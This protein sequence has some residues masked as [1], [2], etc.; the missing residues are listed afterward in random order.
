MGSII[1]IIVP[2]P[3]CTAVVSV[4]NT[5]SQGVV[6]GL[7]ASASSGNLLQMQKKKKSKHKTRFLNSPQ[8]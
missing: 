8:T 3:A 1:L 2:G 5:D 4:Y 7:V 6:P